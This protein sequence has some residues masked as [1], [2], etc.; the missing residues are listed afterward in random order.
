[1][2]VVFG[3][4][5]R[6][7][8]ETARA[9]MFQGEAVRVAV[10]R[11]DQGAGWKKA[12][13]EV[14]VADLDDVE[15]VAA[16]MRGATAA[17]LLNPPPMGGDP[18]ERANRVGST[19][20]EAIR[21]SGL[22]DI[23]VLSSIGAQHSG[24]TG[25]IATLHRLERLL[26]GITPRITFL[27]CGYFVETWEEVA[28]AAIAEGTLPSF[29]QPTQK[30]PMLSTIDVG[31][32]AARLLREAAT[33]NRKAERIVEL[34]GPEDWSA[35]DVAQAFASVLGKPVAPVFVPADERKAMLLGTGLD[36]E[37]A[38]ALAG[39]YEGIADGRVVR[40]DRNE[41]WRGSTSLAVAVKR[42]VAKVGNASVAA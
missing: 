32:A 24:G 34:S 15:S 19:L 13:A 25:V 28:G 42:I 11:D 9:L 27:R 16:A 7:G 21:R 35:I 36:T 8:G 3:A 40:E 12:G 22:V 39:M 14:A 20:A 18:Y 33:V 2:Y 31:A 26:A 17:F 41:Q 23:V 10:R 1:M 5:G 29:L 30:I 38:D 4:N 6:A 37:V